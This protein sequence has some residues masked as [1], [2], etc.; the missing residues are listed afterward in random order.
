MDGICTLANDYV[1]DQL[2]ALLN[3]IEAVYGT[4]MP[5]CIYPY[6]NRLERTLALIRD[7]PQVQIYADTESMQQWDDWA[8][9]AWDTCPTARAIW[10][11]AGSSGYHRFGTHRRYGAFDGPFD[12]FVYMDADTVLLRPLDA[13][14][15]ALEQV[16]FVAYDFQHRDLS[17]VYAA[18]SAKL[19]SL[20]TSEQLQTQIFCSGFYASKRGI[21][22]PEKRQ[23]LLTQLSA[24]DAEILYPMAPDQ[25]LLNY[26][27]MRSP[28]SY[29]NLVFT[30]PSEQ[31]TGNSVTS[32][33]FEVHDH[34][35]YDHG[36][37]LI[38]LHYIG[39]SS[40]RF[41]EL[42]DGQN[43]IFPYRDLFWHYRYWR[44]LD[45][46]PEL[47]GSVVIPPRS[48]PTL[49]Q[50]GWRKVQALMEKQL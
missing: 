14:F 37:P 25:T 19:A 31:V 6:D 9:D 30:L 27:V 1:Y 35:V 39:V 11:K 21:F 38:Y 2:V 45:E 16:E 41:A 10:A 46:P 3:S 33:H 23:E 36:K 29:Q 15:A 18:E 34:H 22:P 28:L 32:S 4:A 24:G 49:W 5:V 12:R 48:R 40:R 26:M 44:S 7:R 42:C 13:L 50:R 8:R 17:H 20:F 47:T 43:V